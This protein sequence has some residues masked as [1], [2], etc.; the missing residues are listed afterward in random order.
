MKFERR[1][2]WLA[3]ATVLTIGLAGVITSTAATA[4]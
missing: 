4:G 2:L 1:R 3:A